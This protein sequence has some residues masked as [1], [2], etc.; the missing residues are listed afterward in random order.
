MEKSSLLLVEEKNEVEY[1]DEK[2]KKEKGKTN[3]RREQ[4]D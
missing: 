2:I 1:N 4:N 3:Q